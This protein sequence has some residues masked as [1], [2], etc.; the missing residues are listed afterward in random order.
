MSGPSR[1]HG[2]DPAGRGDVDGIETL[3][4]VAD[5]IVANAVPG[6][7]VP[8]ARLRVAWLGHKSATAGDG[9]TT[10]SREITNGLRARGV[11]VVFFHHAVGMVDDESVAMEALFKTPRFT[12]HRPR[13]TRQLSDTLLRREVDVVHV[14]L[15]FST[16]DFSLPRLCHKLGI[17]I[18][19]TFHIP[20]D[21][22][23]NIWGAAT[24]GL[25][26]VY[27][28]APLS[29]CDSVIIFG[30][31]QREILISMGVP[32]RVI[33]VL[34]NG[35]DVD[36]YTPGESLKRNEFGAERLFTYLGRVDSEKNV[37]VLLRAFMDAD[38][39]DS[40][41]LVIIG[42]G[43]ER[44][45]LE[46]R[47]HD[48]RIHFTGIIT[49]DAAKI[50]MLRASDAFFLPSSIEGLSLSMLE[51]MACGVATVVTDVGSDGDA[52]RGAGIV[53]D[54]TA[55][56]PELTAAIRLLAEMPE[57]CAVM[58]AMA[59]ARAV[60]RYSLARNLDGLIGL[61]ED[62]AGSRAVAPRPR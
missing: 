22:R 15:S 59:R 45:R 30:D 5:A 11:G 48:P 14:S 19:A 35:V 12:V 9:V 4:P 49:N 24:K 2:Q 31:R 20:F 27:A 46:R 17:P 36:R 58:G 52:V 29:E 8:G 26:R 16:I 13:T 53:L 60:E 54:P 56:Q 28:Q 50:E 51:A 7:P 33:H 37:E 39:R 62:L 18:V 44:R 55:L 42:G 38:P 32:E 3:S 1:E 34:P 25:Y 61:Y 47:Y 40:L 41:H 23:F 57:L 10:Y 21:T 43:T 6:L